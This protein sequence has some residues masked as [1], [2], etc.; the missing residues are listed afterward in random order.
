MQGLICVTHDNWEAAL[1]FIRT[2]GRKDGKSTCIFLMLQTY[3]LNDLIVMQT[4]S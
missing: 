2:Q 3:E 4:G 1:E